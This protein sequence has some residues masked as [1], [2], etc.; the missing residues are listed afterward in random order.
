MAILLLSLLLTL[1]S[2]TWAN[3]F[4]PQ[5]R[6][7]EAGGPKAAD[8]SG[9]VPVV[10]GKEGDG[11][12]EKL[13]AR[14]RVTKVSLSRACGVVIWSGTLEVT[15]LEKI[16]GYPHPKL[17]VVVNCLEDADEKQYLGREVEVEASKLYPRYTK[18]RDVSTFYFEI[19]DNTIDSR[20]VPF[21]CATMSGHDLL[22]P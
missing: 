20:G 17:Y 21:Y 13:K 15:L 14:G 7:P 5:K 2:V 12:P 18:F 11:L 22:K 8:V 16:K 4:V 3:P 19:I 1:I 10:F 6:S 9:P